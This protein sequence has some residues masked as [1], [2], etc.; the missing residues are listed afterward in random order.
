MLSKHQP[1]GI[2][3]SGIGG[4]TVAH[5]V[6]QHLPHEDIIYIGDTAHLPYGDKSA[7]MIRHY[8]RAIA[9]QLLAKGCKLLLVACNSATA[10]AYEDLQA[11]LAGRAQL[12]G[13]IDPVVDYL[14]QHHA[15]QRIGLIGTHQTVN[16][17]VF[18]Q[19][20]KACLPQVHF[21]ALATPLLVPVIEE[22]FH[23]H[24]ELVDAVLKAY[25]GDSALQDVDVLVL[26]CTHYPVIKARLRAY[27]NDRVTLIDAADITAKALAVHLQQADL[28]NLQP[29]SGTRE[30]WVSDLTQAFARQAQGFFGQAIPL[31]LLS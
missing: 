18:A 27:Y 19:K 5:A 7:E 3:D 25:L 22:G 12:L 4:L 2:F 29:V 23:D 10:A 28:L 21:T 9:D 24:C 14:V 6:A 8:V 26:G 30:F 13:V 31:Q 15:S 1:I 17:G 20:L 16:S 11:Y